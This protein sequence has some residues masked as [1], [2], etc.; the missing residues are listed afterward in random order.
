MPG[1]EQRVKTGQG[2]GCLDWCG[3]WAE[4][5]SSQKSVGG[6]DDLLEISRAFHLHVA[7]LDR[8]S[9]LGAILN[10][11]GKAHGRARPET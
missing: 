8:G 1:H 10:G 9:R 5:L 3:S 11:K 6:G 4:L 7:T 2:A